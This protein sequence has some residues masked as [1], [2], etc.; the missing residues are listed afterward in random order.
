MPPFLLTSVLPDYDDVEDNGSNSDNYGAYSEL[1]RKP[2][3]YAMLGESAN[4]LM[5]TRR[6]RFGI[7]DECCTNNCSYKKLA[8]YCV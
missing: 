7:T 5:K 2:L 3:L 4:H 6:R 8:E 1:E